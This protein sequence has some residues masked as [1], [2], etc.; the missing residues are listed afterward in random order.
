LEDT[1]RALMTLGLGLLLILLRLDAERFGA[2]EYDEEVD[3]VRPPLRLRLAWY[4][5]GVGLVA[6][7]LFI[8]PAPGRDLG[9]GLGDRAGAVL[10]GFAYGIAGAMVAVG[11]AYYRYGRLRYPPTGSYPGA[12]VNALLTALIDEAAFRGVLLGLLLLSGM[13]PPIAIVVQALVYSL[14]TRTGARGRPIPIL[15]VTVGIGLVSGWVTVLTAGIGAAFIGH[16]ITRFAVFLTTGHPGGQMPPR[17]EELEEVYRSRTIP[18]GWRPISTRDQRV[19]VP[20][21][22]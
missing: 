15:L 13:D 4:I 22:R 5:L 20:R 12:L 17:G 21:E 14:A 2:A 16:G 9:L 8:H 18:E 19:A 10:L 11:L 6:A 7:I 3:G 1:L